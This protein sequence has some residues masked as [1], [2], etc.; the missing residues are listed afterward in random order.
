MNES[1]SRPWHII[2]ASL[3]AGLILVTGCSE[4]T[5]DGSPTGGS[6][7]IPPLTVETLKNTAYGGIYDEAV[8]LI[9]G[10]YEGE[11]FVE[12]GASRPTVTLTDAYAFGD[13]NGDGVKD[14]AVIL[15]ESSGGSG[16]FCY[17]A[18]V[19][20]QDG[21]PENIATETLGD[22]VQVASV[23]IDGAEITVEA[24]THGPADPM[25]CPTQEVTLVYGLDGERLVK[26]A[27][28][29]AGG[30]APAALEG[31]Q[32]RLVSYA[33][34][35]GET[36]NVLPETEITAEFTADQI[37]GG[38][39]CNLYTG[40]YHG[41][42]AAITFGPISATEKWCAEP[43]GTMAQERDFLATLEA[44]TGYQVEANALALLDANGAP[45]ATFTQ[46]G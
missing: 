11:P 27:E 2:A 35:Q 30:D 15:V 28:E 10:Q 23:T 1:F 8:Q 24:K 34:G 39:G 40:S 26:L 19:L 4:T 41:D 16:S 17:L 13:L 21:N 36:V 14:A 31:T 33:N 29:T 9:D 43:D 44:A 6:E 18:V 37:T 38:A 25:C 32:W 22:R 45:I 42:D 12:G 46:A 7:T 3:L 20:N 5:P